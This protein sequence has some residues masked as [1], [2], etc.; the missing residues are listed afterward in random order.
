MQ[1]FGRTKPTDTT[2]DTQSAPDHQ[3]TRIIDNIPEGLALC[4]PDGTIA[5]RNRRLH[6]MI[7]EAGGVVQDADTFTTLIKVVPY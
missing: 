4:C 5:L 3:L 1:G 7:N 2:P 6:T